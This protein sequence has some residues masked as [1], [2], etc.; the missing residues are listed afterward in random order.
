MPYLSFACHPMDSRHVSPFS[1]SS[2]T[3]PRR[4]PSTEATSVSCIQSP[5][6]GAHKRKGDHLPHYPRKQS[7]VTQGST[8]R[9]EPL[10]RDGEPVHKLYHEAQEGKG[11]S[12]ACTEV[13]LDTCSGLPAHLWRR[14]F[15]YLPPKSLG[16]LL[17]VNQTFNRYLGGTIAHPSTEENTTRTLR[18]GAEEIWTKARK[19]H[20]HHLPRPLSTHSELSMWKL[21]GGRSCQFCT[22]EP[23]SRNGHSFSPVPGPRGQAIRIYWTLG[24]RC[25]YNCLKQ[26]T[27]T[28]C[29]TSTQ[30]LYKR[31]GVL[32]SLLERP[33]SL[34]SPLQH[35]S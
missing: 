32:N 30:K 28:V 9:K 33:I 29:E 14:V 25:C 1:D 10:A 26:E 11:S 34:S 23:G 27:I 18:S 21:I 12:G 7:R 3:T 22:Y 16:Q 19:L 6:N 17:S 31:A 2:S 8:G 24:I 15:M 20:H 5:V 4:S 13:P 35:I